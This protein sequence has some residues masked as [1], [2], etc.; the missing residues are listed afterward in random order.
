MRVERAW[1]LTPAPTL[2][3]ADRCVQV[4]NKRHRVILVHGRKKLNY[5]WELRALRT[6]HQGLSLE[7]IITTRN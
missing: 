7:E 3:G 6:F 4:T 5:H 1:F 2:N